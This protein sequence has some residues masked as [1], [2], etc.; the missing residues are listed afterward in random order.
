VTPSPNAIPRNPVLNIVS[1]DH[2][3]PLVDY[4]ARNSTLNK[5]DTKKPA[6]EENKSAGPDSMKPLYFSVKK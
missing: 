1:S 6:S 4:A 5:D 3:N 2:G